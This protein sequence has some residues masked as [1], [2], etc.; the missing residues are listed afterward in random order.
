MRK[1]ANQLCKYESR[2]YL[3]SMMRSRRRF[4]IPEL[5]DETWY[6]ASTI[7]HYL[8]C[9]EAAGYV[10]CVRPGAAFHPACWELVRDASEPPRVR[11]DG[12]PVTQGQG[13]DNMWRAMRILKRFSVR[14]LVAAA[15]TDEHEVKETEAQTY[16]GYLAKAGYL[17]RS[18]SAYFLIRYTGPRAPQVQRVRRVFDPNLKEVVWPSR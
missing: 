12:S 6:D 8:K 14:D 16:C 11:I 5:R 15:S 18:G 17:R 10:R 13:R 3:W 7:A 1:P 4:T 2:E 9:L